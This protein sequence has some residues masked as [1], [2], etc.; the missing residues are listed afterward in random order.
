MVKPLELFISKANSETIYTLIH[1]N[2]PMC[3]D[4]RT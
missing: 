3:A 2:H 1:L 4:R